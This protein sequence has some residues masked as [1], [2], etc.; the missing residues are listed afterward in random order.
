L[1]EKLAKPISIAGSTTYTIDIP[2]AKG[3]LIKLG[4]GWGRG[5]LFEW[6]LKTEN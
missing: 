4:G 2:K 1:F 5:A 3:S 6:T